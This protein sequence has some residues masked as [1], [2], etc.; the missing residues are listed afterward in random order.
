M[1]NNPLFDTDFLYEL[2]HYRNRIVY[3]RILSLTSENYPIEQIEGVATGGDITIDGASSVRRVVSLTM[4]T[5]NL[6]INNI[7]WGLNAR[8][9]IEVGLEN[10]FNPEYPKIIWFP[11]G[12]FLITEFKTS[13]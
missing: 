11:Q 13:S 2:D 7:Y 4:T 10:K 3:V 8:V 12:V 5:K 9:K 1:K 6:N